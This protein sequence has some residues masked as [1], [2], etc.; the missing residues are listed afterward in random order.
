[1]SIGS[2]RKNSN[3]MQCKTGVGGVDFL[4][5]HLIYYGFFD[6]SL[7]IKNI[8]KLLNVILTPCNIKHIKMFLGKNSC[9]HRYSWPGH[10]LPI[11]MCIEKLSP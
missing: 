1:M 2:P 8:L 10:F 11:T 5:Y 7:F 9:T 6:T 4:L 3:A